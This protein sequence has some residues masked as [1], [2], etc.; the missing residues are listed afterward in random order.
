MK[1]HVPKNNKEVKD[2]IKYFNYCHDGCI[3]TVC[4]RKKCDIDGLGNL[5]F[6]FENTKDFLVCDIEMEMLLNSYSKAKKNQVIKLYFLETDVFQFFQK[7]NFDYS[8]IYQ[9]SFNRNNKK[10]N[11]IFYS[12]D[13]EIKSL[14][15]RCKELIIREL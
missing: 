6:S 5:I 2:L 11:F 10:I 14:I 15:I 7:N 3:R 9:V 1:I 13:K 12:T 4:F 8:Q